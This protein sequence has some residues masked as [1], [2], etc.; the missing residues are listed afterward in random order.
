M[1]TLERIDEIEK[2]IKALR[3]QLQGLQDNAL[4]K[5]EA[6]K[7]PEKWV[8]KYGEDMIYVDAAG[9]VAMSTYPHESLFIEIMVERGL[10][11]Q[12]REEAEYRAQWLLAHPIVKPP[13]EVG[14][15]V[16]VLHGDNWYWRDAWD[17]TTH[18]LA[19]WYGGCIKAAQ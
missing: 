14:D 11:F 16:Q 7:E 3:L 8:P 18:D 9:N 4:E 6:Q 15:G 13:F 5:L 2:T 17:G 1:T 19:L 12:T 10:L